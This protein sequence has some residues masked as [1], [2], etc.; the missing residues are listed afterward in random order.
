M[1]TIKKD[2]CDSWTEIIGN[3]TNG[4]IAQYDEGEGGIEVHY[5]NYHYVVFT[6]HPYGGEYVL[7]GY[8]KS[9]QEDKMIEFLERIN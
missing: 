9:G 4:N 2:W 5:I 7:E 3:L 1:A 6:V 8:Y